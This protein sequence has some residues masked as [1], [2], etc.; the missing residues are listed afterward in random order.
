MVEQ[1]DNSSPVS[2]VSNL[3]LGRRTLVMGIINVTPDSFSGDGLGSDVD[4]AVA[5]A[6]RMAAEGADL[7][8]IGGQSTRPASEP[9]PVEEELRRVIPVIERLRSGHAVHLP[10]SIDT[11]R[12]QVA[13]AALEAG[14]DI[15][16]DISGLRDDPSIAAIAARHGAGLILMHIQ[17][18]PRTM[19]INPH[20]ENLLAEVIDYLRGG[21]EKA[22]Q[23]GVPRE[24]I[25][26]DP[27]IGFGKTLEH[28]LELL[29]RLGELRVLGCPIMVGTSRKAFI[30]RLLAPLHGGEAP[31]PA[32]RIAGTGATIALSIANGA[33]IVRVHD[34]APA[35]E[36]ARV[37]DAIVRDLRPVAPLRAGSSSYVE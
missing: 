33:D 31:P 35:V 7:L 16:N 2:P 36:V 32:E 13:N 20:Y 17:G 14:A 12:G 25:W 6:H 19:Q 9:V 24:R 26:V 15:V 22:E 37:A 27:G 1:R 28:N 23:A 3:P 30:G 18:T 34:V 5:Q 21:I 11:N 4:A 8:D 29:R 10:I